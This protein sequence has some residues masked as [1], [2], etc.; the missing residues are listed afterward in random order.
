M[1]TLWVNDGA[2]ICARRLYQMDELRWDM[3]G[4]CFGS[5]FMYDILS[6]HMKKTHRNS[7]S[8]VAATIV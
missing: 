3:F 2:Q 8:Y 7:Y 4:R 6:W 5:T 1:C